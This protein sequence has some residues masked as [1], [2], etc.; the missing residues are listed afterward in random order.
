M[1]SNMYRKYLVDIAVYMVQNE[2]WFEKPINY[3]SLQY[4]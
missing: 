4:K 1:K 3:D 2:L